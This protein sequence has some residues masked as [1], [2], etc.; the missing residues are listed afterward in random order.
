MGIPRK[1]RFRKGNSRGIPI[2]SRPREFPVWE[3]PPTSPARVVR[4]LD[5]LL[6]CGLARNGLPRF[7]E[8]HADTRE[9]GYSAAVFFWQIRRMDISGFQRSLALFVHKMGPYEDS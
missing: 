4:V 5:T 8:A 2:D 6:G 9:C 7:L 1:R 3:F